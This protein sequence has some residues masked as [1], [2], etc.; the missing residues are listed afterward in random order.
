MTLLHH[1][2]LLNFSVKYVSVPSLKLSKCKVNKYK[3]WQLVNHQ[4][5]TL[6]FKVWIELG[7]LPNNSD[8]YI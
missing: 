4:N 7:N 8:V 6:S 1:T 3:W 2:T 5:L